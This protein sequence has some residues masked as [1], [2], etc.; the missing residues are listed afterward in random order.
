M[1][2]A[3]YPAMLQKLLAN[4]YCGS[5][6]GRSS[7]GNQVCNS[8]MTVKGVLEGLQMNNPATA[9]PCSWLAQ[10]GQHLTRPQ[11]ATH[12]SFNGISVRIRIAM[13]CNSMPSVETPSAVMVHQRPCTGAPLLCCLSCEWIEAFNKQ[14]QLDHELCL[15]TYD[16]VPFCCCTIDTQPQFRDQA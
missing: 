8:L 9:E 12:R 3:L 6:A 1:V 11:H 5:L 16:M 4:D 10:R 15:A 14:H 7:S 2:Y 13:R